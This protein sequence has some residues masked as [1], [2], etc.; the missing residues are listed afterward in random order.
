MPVGFAAK[1]VPL[2]LALALSFA[3]LLLGIALGVLIGKA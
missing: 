3:C 2:W 1:Q